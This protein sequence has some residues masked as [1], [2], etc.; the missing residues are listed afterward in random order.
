MVVKLGLVDGFVVAS[1]EE[2]EEVEGS[3]SAE[4]EVV[5]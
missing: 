3:A 5:L 1:E 2:E 4:Q